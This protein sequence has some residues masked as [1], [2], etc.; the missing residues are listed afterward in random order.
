[1]TVLL[2]NRYGRRWQGISHG[3][4]LGHGPLAMT[5]RF[6]VKPI[7]PL[8]A[9]ALLSCSPEATESPDVGVDDAW[10][11]ATLPGKP[12]SAA[13]LT[14]SN[15]GGADDA[16]IG[17]SSSSGTAEV[18]ST[19]MDGGIMRMR[20]LQRLPIPAGTTV[21]LEPRGAH[22]MLTGLREPLL[23]GK[24]IQLTLRFTSSPPRTAAAEI[25]ASSGDH[26]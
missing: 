21:K 1:M 4:L 12:A 19:S 14:I 9:M 8:L 15:R 13:Y 6:P 24:H 3:V 18:H 26:M 20:K 16:L 17:V 11:R 2:R 22:V 10:A 7:V 5:A 25:R 23:A